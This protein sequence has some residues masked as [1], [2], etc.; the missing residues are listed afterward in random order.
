MKTIAVTYEAC[1]FVK[2]NLGNFNL[3]KAIP[4]RHPGNT[5]SKI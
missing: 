2:P 4:D 5:N 1:V 3:V